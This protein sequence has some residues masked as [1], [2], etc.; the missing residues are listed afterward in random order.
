MLKKLLKLWDPLEFLYLAV[1]IATLNHT[2]WAMS[3]AFEG[4]Y[5]GHWTWYLEGLLIAI[6]IDVGMLYTSRM[7]ASATTRGARLSLVITFVIAALGSLY[8]QL[9]YLLVRTPVVQMTEGVSPA[10]QAALQP[11][12]EARV[13]ILPALLPILAISYTLA[14]VF[15]AK[16]LISQSTEEKEKSDLQESATHLETSWRVKKEHN[17]LLEDSPIQRA[18]PV[19]SDG[20]DRVNWETLI[21]WDEVSRSWKGPYKDAETLMRRWKALQT[22]R[23]RYGLPKYATRRRDDG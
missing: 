23:I 8:A 6:A 4:P 21:F 17:A 14:R 7:L 10:W 11:L 22:Q 13:V 20:P 16:T 12:L 2:S 3:Y 1:A 9:L 18:L 19:A 15:R 5:S